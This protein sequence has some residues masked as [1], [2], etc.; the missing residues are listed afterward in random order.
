MN[1]KRALNPQTWTDVASELCMKAKANVKNTVR[2]SW[3]LDPDMLEKTIIEWPFQYFRPVLAK[4]GEPIRTGLEH[5]VPV[6][7]LKIPQNHPRLINFIL[8]CGNQIYPIAIDPHDYVELQSKFVSESFIYFKM[9]FREEGYPFDN[10][11]P[12]G[13]IPNDSSLYSYLSNLRAIREQK[14]PLFAVYGRFGPDFAE[15]V[16]RKALGI[17]NRQTLFSFEGGHKIVRYSRFLKEVARSRICIDL[18]G[19]GDLCL[20]LVDYL[21]VGA[22]IIGPRHHNILHVPLE[23]D[24]HIIYAKDDLSDL[25][26]LCRYYLDHEEKRINLCRSS[27]DFFDRY[28]HRQQ[29]AAYYLSCCF[30]KIC[31][32][33]SD[34]CTSNPRDSYRYGNDV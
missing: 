8:R 29:L 10:V 14:A 2:P 21:A 23:N 32:S 19:N 17:L 30:E 1:W 27:M 9:Q 34:C 5:Y 4:W 25:L 31:P 3:N 22:C 16:R 13:Y 24:R 15:D 28:L 20:R 26:D 18:P 12:G 7:G 11:M 33:E 6:K